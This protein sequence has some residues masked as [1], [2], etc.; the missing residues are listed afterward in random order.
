[1]LTMI[2]QSVALNVNSKNVFLF[3]GIVS[4]QHSRNIYQYFALHSLHLNLD[5]KYTQQVIFKLFNYCKWLYIW[6]GLYFANI[7]E[8]VHSWNYSFRESLFF[9]YYQIVCL[10]LIVQVLDHWP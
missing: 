3:C 7:R 2:I 8:Q 9:N 4:F 6:E 10:S 5:F 1:M